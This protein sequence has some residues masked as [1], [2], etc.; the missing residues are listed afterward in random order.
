MGSV[1]LARARGSLRAGIAVALV[2]AGTC[3]AAAEAKV[4]SAPGPAPR[5]DAV[6][7]GFSDGVVLFGGRGSTGA[8][9]DMWIWGHSGWARVEP[10]TGPSALVWPSARSS[11]VMTRDDDALVLFGGENASGHLGDTWLWKGGGWVM[12]QPD[13]VALIP[14]RAEAAMAPAPEGGALLYGGRNV[15]GALHDTWRWTGSAWLQVDLEP[16]LYVPPRRWGHG[17]ASRRD[18]VVLFGGCAALGCKND[19]WI[20]KGAAWNDISPINSTPP[21]RRRDHVMSLVRPGGDVL[22]FGGVEGTTLY[23][24]TWTLSGS[25]WTP[26]AADQEA[27]PARTGAAAAMLPGG[28]GVIV[29]GGQGAKGLLADTWIWNG[30]SWRKVK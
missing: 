29:F 2:T 25:N 7:A 23:G 10:P 5:S 3:A 12:A 1:R 6:M 4:G 17:M 9:D 13:A 11:A 21:A 15:A 27:P 30:T 19:L 24:D 8:L 26:L 18:D 16:G 22:V 20:W 28:E 14:A